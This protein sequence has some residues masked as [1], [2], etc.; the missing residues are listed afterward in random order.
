[1]SRIEVDRDRCVGSGTCEAL[2]PDVFEVDDDGVLVVHR[3]EPGE[4]ELDDVRDAVQ[5]CP[6]R[7]LALAD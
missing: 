4:E 6:T 3:E 5:A 2:A 1:M 7:A